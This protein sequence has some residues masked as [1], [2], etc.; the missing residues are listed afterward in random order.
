MKL[1]GQPGSGRRPSEQVE[2]F[3][4]VEGKL[5]KKVFVTP[6]KPGAVEKTIHL[7]GLL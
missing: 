1:L 5:K 6:E 3:G 4:M 7:S 2:V